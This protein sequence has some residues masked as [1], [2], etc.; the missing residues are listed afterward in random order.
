MNVEKLVALANDLD[1]KGLSE[2]ADKLDAILGEM[3]GKTIAAAEEKKERQTSKKVMN[4]FKRLNEAAQKA[5]DVDVD[6]RG[7]YRILFDK[8]RFEAQEICEL[9][10]DIEF[11]PE[12][13]QEAAESGQIEQ[14]LAGEQTMEGQEGA[15][16]APVEEAVVAIP[17]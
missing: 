14:N 6:T 12:G 10:K 9:L 17:A 7:P 11:T 15:V 3:T 16:P 13:E 2:E 4:V 1:Q 5:C 8:A